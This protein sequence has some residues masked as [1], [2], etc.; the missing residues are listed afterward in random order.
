MGLPLLSGP[1]EH[2]DST[3]PLPARL[4]RLGALQSRLAERPGL[5]LGRRDAGAHQRSLDRVHAALAE[6]L[7][8]LSCAARIGVAVDA[9]LDVRVILH[10]LAELVDLAGLRAPDRALVEVEQEVRERHP[11]PLR[12]RR[13]THAL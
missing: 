1:D 12:A 7:V 5:D 11:G 8:V 9:D 10:V 13:A 3:V 6:G 2:F 4:G